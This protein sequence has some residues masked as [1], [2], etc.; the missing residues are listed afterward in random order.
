MACKRNNMIRLNFQICSYQ[1][2]DYYIS[3]PPEF[4]GSMY[5]NICNKFGQDMTHRNPINL[6]RNNIPALFQE[7]DSLLNINMFSMKY[8]FWT[9]QPGNDIIINDYFNYDFK[10]IHPKSDKKLT[11]SI[12]CQVEFFACFDPFYLENC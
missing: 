3:W 2:C 7:S 9:L 12:S 11:F 5:N 10:L 8:Q 1:G 4:T 6:Q